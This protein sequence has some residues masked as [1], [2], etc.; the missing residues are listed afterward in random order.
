MDIK[1]ITITARDMRA[2]RRFQEAY[3]LVVERTSKIQGL[4][5]FAWEHQPIFWSDIE[6][7]I[8]KLTRR[9]GNDAAFIEEIW[10][11][12]DFVYSF[13]RHAAGISKT[14]RELEEI[15]EGEF[16]STLGVSKSLH[17]I[18]RDKSSRPWGILSLT[19]IS[20]THKRAE[21]MLGVL[22]GAPKGLS[23]S[24]MLIL[25]QFFFKAMNFNKLYSF[26]YDDNMHSLKGTLHLGFKEEGRL[27]NHVLD[28]KS[29]KYV[30]LIQTGLLAEDA[31]NPTNKKLMQRLMSQSKS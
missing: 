19:E 12:K 24:A 17:W 18:V 25:F 8:C 20:L 10:S 9:N 31:L 30:D 4:K 1:E 5:G 6:A 28:P 2:N 21:V 15:L 13:H 7:G 3:Q 23:V 11:Q 14:K 16:I 27:R 29:G 26:V 22:P